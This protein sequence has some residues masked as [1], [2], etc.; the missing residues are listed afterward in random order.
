MLYRTVP[1]STSRPLPDT[2]P[3]SPP[4]P[5]ASTMSSSRSKNA[6]FGPNN[7]EE[8]SVAALLVAVEAW[9]DRAP[10][11]G[12]IHVV[13]EALRAVEVLLK[14]FERTDSRSF[15]L[16]YPSFSRRLFISWILL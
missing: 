6:V 4:T 11:V 8:D 10:V 15:S 7:S 1:L 2:K 9:A 14:K 13:A 3:L 16:L 12:S 5:T